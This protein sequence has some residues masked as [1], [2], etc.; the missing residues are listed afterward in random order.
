MDKQSRRNR[1]FVVF[2]TLVVLASMMV[3]GAAAELIAR[4]LESTAEGDI[5]QLNDADLGWLPKPGN[6]KITTRADAADRRTHEHS[7]E[8]S[9]INGPGL[10]FSAW[11]GGTGL[12]TRWQ[13]AY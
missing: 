3:I 1:P 7:R 4:S 13:H 9:A 8:R 11:F 6:Y 2:L 5:T 12:D 10:S